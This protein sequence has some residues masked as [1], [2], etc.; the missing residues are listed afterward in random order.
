MLIE[1][2]ILRKLRLRF[3]HHFETSFGRTYKKECLIVEA[4]GEGLSGWGECVA[5]EGPFYSYE[6]HETSWHIVS[7]YIASMVVGKEISAVDFPAIVGSIRGHP[8][9]KAAVE[10]ALW[11]WEAKS[12]GLPLW[13]LLGGTRAK[14]PCGVSIG[15]QDSV[16]ELLDLICRE[17]DAGYQKI[18]LKIKPGWDLDILHIVRE[19][20][21]DIPL[22][23]DANSAYCVNDFDHLKE[24]DRFNLMMIEQPLFYDD[25]FE[26]S[27]LQ[28]VLDTPICLDESI[29]HRRDAKI[30]INL[31]ACQIINIKMGRVGG[32][33]EARRIHDLCK[34]AGLAVWCGG[35]LETGIGRAH[36]IALSTLDNFSIP[37]DVSASKRYFDRDVILEPVE[38]TSDGHIIPPDSPGIGFEV[39]RQWIDSNSSRRAVFG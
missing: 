31:G 11:D 36:N 29:L 4:V 10:A 33:V 14:V 23:A 27:R 26:H 38:V 1:Q 16:D 24:L 20:F 34:N 37:G 28:R 21:P 39:D 5:A 12:Q 17:V 22:M 9:A 18:K 2:L 30:A 8:M 19:R 3:V 25:I 15:I 6:D 7:E 13:K 35:M 32:F